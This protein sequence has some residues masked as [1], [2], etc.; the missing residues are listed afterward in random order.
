MKNKTILPD[1]G[2]DSMHVVV[3]KDAEVGNV[4]M[5]V[6]CKPK[7]NDGKRS[8]RVMIECLCGR[9]IPFGR[10]HQHFQKCTGHRR[11]NDEV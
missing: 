6:K 11:Y 2:F 5:N 10:M 4:R 7:G 8:H 3:G 1:E 9:E